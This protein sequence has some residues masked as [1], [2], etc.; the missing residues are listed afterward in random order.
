MSAVNRSTGHNL[1]LNKPSLWEVHQN[2]LQGLIVAQ[3][4][5]GSIKLVQLLHEKGRCV[6]LQLR[7]LFINLIL[8]RVVY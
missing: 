2:L 1:N 5:S 8:L 4:F 7:I 6:A 3:I